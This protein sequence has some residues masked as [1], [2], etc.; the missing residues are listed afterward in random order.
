[1]K[2]HLASYSD[3]VDGQEAVA[4]KKPELIYA[5][6]EAHP[7]TYHIVPDKS[8][9]SRMN[10]CF[11]VNKASCSFLAMQRITADGK[12]QGGNVEETEKSFLKQ[13]TDLGLNGLKGHRSVGGI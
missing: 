13:S 6:L 10:I 7:D 11:R 5:A 3:K 12:H 9:R 1:M 2:K 4:D 8:V